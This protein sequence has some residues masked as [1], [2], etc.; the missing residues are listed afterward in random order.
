MQYKIFIGSFLLAIPY[1]FLLGGL[2]ATRPHRIFFFAFLLSL[3]VVVASIYI[4]KPILLKDET[5][6]KKRF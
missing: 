2:S 4:L 6:N 1:F 3:A 5:K